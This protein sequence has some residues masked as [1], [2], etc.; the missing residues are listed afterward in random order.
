MQNSEAVD[1]KLEKIH[2]LVNSQMTAA[3]QAELNAVRRE[4]AMMRHVEQLNETLRK[5]QSDG[6][7]GPAELK[8]SDESMQTA[9]RRIK[10]LEVMIA[11]RLQA[12][13]TGLKREE[14]AVKREDV[15][16]KKLDIIAADQESLRK[17][18]LGI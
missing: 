12:T 2:V 11:E 6:S 18:S 4:L 3:L 1:G 16:M 14:A 13:E 10:E 15:A 7:V 9:E 8:A 5:T 17:A